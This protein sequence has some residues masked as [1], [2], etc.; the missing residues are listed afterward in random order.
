MLR[1][2]HFY[3]GGSVLGEEMLKFYLSDMWNALTYNFTILYVVV[4]ILARLPEVLF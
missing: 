1:N 4:K 2:R 3:T